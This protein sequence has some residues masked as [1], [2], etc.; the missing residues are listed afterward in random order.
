MERILGLAVFFEHFPS[1][2]QISL[3]MNKQDVQSIPVY[4]I[5]AFFKVLEK[6]HK[7]DEGC[8]WIRVNFEIISDS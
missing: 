8:D 4:Q 7:F 3:V 5:L 6:N 1:I 2:S